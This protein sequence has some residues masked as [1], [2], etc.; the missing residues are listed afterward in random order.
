[1]PH[2][3]LLDRVAEQET[4][5]HLLGEVRSGL[6]QVLV[7]SGEP[8]AG[9]T[10]MLER[11]V[12][13]AGDFRI[14][15][16]LGVES[17]LA[18]PLAGLHQLLVPFLARHQSLPPPQQQALRCAFGLAEGPV[19]ERFLVGLAALTLVSEAA[20]EQPLLIVIDDAQWLDRESGELIA[21]VARRLLADRVAMLFARRDTGAE[22]GWLDGLPELRI[23]GL[24]DADARA[25]LA[26]IEIPVM[27]ERVRERFLAI[28][29]GNP[30]ALIEL[31]GA[32]TPDELAGRARLR[33]PV[34]LGARMEEHFLRQVRELPQETQEFL[35]L[36]AADP[37][38]DTGV[39]SR[40]AGV[41]GLSEDAPTAAELKRLITLAP[42]IAFRHP[43]IRSAIYHHAPAARTTSRAPG[44]GRGHQRE[45]CGP[46]RLAFGRRCARAR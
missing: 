26:S 30:L 7:I 6:S 2:R 19:P 5:A 11:V 23:G 36:A 1:M 18:L 16:V 31:T 13:L 38:G 35:L 24:P 10:A 43:L 45:R 4:L 15:R 9:K 8:G 44:A 32:L 39:V 42:G 27:H 12:E 25:L 22:R 37:T 28:T 46:A 41:L 3:L 17:E 33:D 34:P 21:F 29:G 14:V 40:A 20:V